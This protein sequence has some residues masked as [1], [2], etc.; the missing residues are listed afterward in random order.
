M[1]EDGTITLPDGTV[2]DPADMPRRPEGQGDRGPGGPG[3]FRPG[4]EGQ[5]GESEPS[6]IFT[7]QNGGNMFY[8]VGKPE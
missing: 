2:I 6:D 3:G 8:G 5:T 4:M 7:I 1:N